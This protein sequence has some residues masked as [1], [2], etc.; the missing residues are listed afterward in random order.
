MKGF[1]ESSTHLP[2]KIVRL[3]WNSLRLFV[4]R[5]NA[6]EIH[7]N[8]ELVVLNLSTIDEFSVLKMYFVW[9]QND[10]T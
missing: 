9:P 6:S 1:Y 2:M 3:I 7:C 8:Y 5:G 4:R 10:L